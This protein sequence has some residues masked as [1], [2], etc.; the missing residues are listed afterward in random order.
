[1]NLNDAAQNI[2]GGIYI[3]VGFSLLLLSAWYARPKEGAG[4][5]WGI[6]GGGVLGTALVIALLFSVS[7]LR[8]LGDTVLGWFGI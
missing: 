4:F 5:R 6:F 8:N 2:W 7:R 3:F 1:M